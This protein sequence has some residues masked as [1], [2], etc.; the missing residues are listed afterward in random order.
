M[1]T[2][3]YDEKTGR[4]C[5]PKTRN[6]PHTHARAG[7]SSVLAECSNCIRCCSLDDKRRRRRPTSDPMAERLRNAAAT[8]TKQQVMVGARTYAH[9]RGTHNNRVPHDDDDDDDGYNGGGGNNNNRRLEKNP[10]AASLSHSLT[11]TARTIFIACIHA[12][13][14]PRCEHTNARNAHGRDDN[15]TTRSGK[16]F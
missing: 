5:L 11:R 13:R 3:A 4:C 8:R 7:P 9:D 2:V 15:T 16:R 1:R 14:G 10:A 6:T 12:L